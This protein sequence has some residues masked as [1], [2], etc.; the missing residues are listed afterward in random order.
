[1]Q[2]FMYLFTAINNTEICRVYDSILKFK[3]RELKLGDQF[4]FVANQKGM[5][6]RKLLFRV[7]LLYSARC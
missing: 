6:V 7:N 4:Q 5:N 2:I 3:D 1:M